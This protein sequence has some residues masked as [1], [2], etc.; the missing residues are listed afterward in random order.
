MRRPIPR[1]IAGSV[2]LAVLAVRLLVPGGQPSAQGFQQLAD[3]VV[4][5]KTARFQ[6]EVDV[7]GQARQK[8]QA[9]YLAPGKFR[10]ELGS[11]VNIADFSAGKSSRSC[12][13]RKWPW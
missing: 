8:F 2:C 11:V 3:A 13:P 6:M 5:A 10:Q 1:L 7:Q 9:Y 4:K 12:R